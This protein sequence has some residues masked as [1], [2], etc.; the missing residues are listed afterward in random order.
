MP[1]VSWC[2]LL[3]RGHWAGVGDLEHF[4]LFP[5]G[6]SNLDF[7]DVLVFAQKARDAAFFLFRAGPRVLVLPGE[8]HDIIRPVIHAGKGWTRS[9]G[10]EEPE[11]LRTE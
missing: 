4:E 9:Y 6:F 10:T 3:L 7:E 11:F 1:S 2:A 5:L 8:V